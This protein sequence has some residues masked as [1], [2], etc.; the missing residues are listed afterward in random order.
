MKRKG[1]FH[2][3]ELSAAWL[4]KV[5]GTNLE[6]L[7]AGELLLQLSK[8]VRPDGSFNGFSRYAEKVAIRLV[9]NKRDDEG[10]ELFMTIVDVKKNNRILL[11]HRKRD[12]YVSEETA[13]THGQ[14][15]YQGVLRFGQV[16]MRHEEQ[17]LAKKLFLEL[18]ERIPTICFP[19]TL[20]DARLKALEHLTTLGMKTLS[21]GVPITEELETARHHNGC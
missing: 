15:G 13:D 6:M 4:E 10:L 17:W 21:S 12:M 18:V 7:L 11:V 19:I 20:S 3:F 14:L 16:A 2:P 5:A 1:A 9:E 8:V